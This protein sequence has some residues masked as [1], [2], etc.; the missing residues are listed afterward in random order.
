MSILSRR[1]SSLNWLLL[2]LAF[3]CISD[4]IT[5]APAAADDEG[6]TIPECCRPKV[7]Q[8]AEV[9]VL[10]LRKD[11]CEAS[12]VIEPLFLQAREELT[13]SPVL[14]LSMDFSTSAESTRSEYLCRALRLDG[15]WS[16]FARQSG[17]L[18]IADART[19]EPVS[20]ITRFDS[21]ERLLGEVQ[22]LLREKP[23][24]P[25]PQTN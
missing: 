21:K 3:T 11:D 19:L 13:S 1:P 20:K 15:V 12:K 25:L 22:R 2:F 6:S 17:F 8:A 23:P 10:L 16:R 18:V 9:F 14:F 24:L 4:T 5:A 7:A